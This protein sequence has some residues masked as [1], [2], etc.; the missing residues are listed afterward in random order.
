MSNE[1]LYLLLFGVASRRWLGDSRLLGDHP[2]KIADGPTY[3]I[4]G[5]E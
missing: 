5:Y 1:S 4:N 3:Y 2:I